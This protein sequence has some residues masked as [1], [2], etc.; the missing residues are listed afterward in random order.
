MSASK[1]SGP[2]PSSVTLHLGSPAATHDFGRRLGAVVTPG[3]VI[4]LSGE[5]GAGKTTLTQGIAAGLGIGARVT[6]PT[7]TLVN[8]YKQGERRLLL[9]HIDTYRLGD[10]AAS[11]QIEALNLGMDEILN[12]APLPDDHTDGAV[13]VIEWAERIRELLPPNTLYIH[14]TPAPDEE[15]ARTATLTAMGPEV[16]KVL[17]SFADGE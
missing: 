5:L 11:A 17:R 9:V 7:F 3:Q 8:Q 15:N 14:L 1:I 4:A 2:A 6:S 13:V 12:D 16:G 10:D